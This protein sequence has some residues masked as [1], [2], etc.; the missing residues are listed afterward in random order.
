V[1]EQRMELVFKANLPAE[2][3]EDKRCGQIA[4]WRGKNIDSFAAKQIVGVGL[5]AFDGH[6]DVE[7]S[8]TGE[9]NF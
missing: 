7:C 6:E 8:S 3:A 9:G 2:D 4:V 1:L 5:A